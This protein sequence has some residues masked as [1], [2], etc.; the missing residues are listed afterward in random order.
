MAGV[1]LQENVE[2]KGEMV[3]EEDASVTFKCTLSVLRT[4]T[5]KCVEP[6]DTRN[7]GGLN[8]L[9]TRM[10]IACQ[11]GKS[12]QGMAVFMATKKFVQED[13]S[14]IGRLV[15][16]KLLSMRRSALSLILEIVTCLHIYGDACI[17]NDHNG[18]IPSIKYQD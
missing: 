1:Y 18:V 6:F 14:M 7:E 9:T 2:M 17:I 16:G 3:K 8:K 12:L 11:N 15:I 13:A 5:N 4:A 10:V